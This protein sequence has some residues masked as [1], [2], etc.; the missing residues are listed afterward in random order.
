[1]LA[2]AWLRAIV[3]IETAGVAHGDVRPSSALVSADLQVT[4]VDLDHVWAVE[5][6]TP[7]RRAPAMRTLFRSCRSRL[8]I[9]GR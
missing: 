4:F 5:L 3:Q 1:M 6:A 9:C 7:G 8:L 2:E